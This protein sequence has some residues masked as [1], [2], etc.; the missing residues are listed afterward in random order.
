MNKLAIELIKQ[1]EGLRLKPY[2]DTLGYK[3]IGYGRNLDSNGISESEAEFLLMKDIMT[4]TID[5]YK[6]IPKVM[7][8]VGNDRQAV[9][10]DMMFNLGMPRFSKFRKMIRALEEEDYARAAAEMIDSKW[11]KQVG[12]RSFRLARIMKDGHV[13]S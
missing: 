1:H 10:I 11:S 12:K 6:V 13:A 9:L 3:T 7:G 5:C 2:S 8:R 4:A